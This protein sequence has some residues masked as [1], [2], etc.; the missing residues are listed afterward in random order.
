MS[1]LAPPAAAAD[2]YV[3]TGCAGFIGSHLTDALVARRNTVVGIDGFSDYYSR[4]RKEANLAGLSDHP[5]FRLIEG[6]VCEA[7][8]SRLLDGATGIFH[9]AAQ[10][11][12]RGSWGETFEVYA[13]DNI[14]ATQ[15]VLGAAAATDPRVVL[16]SSSSVYGNA[17]TYPTAEDTRP[18]PISPYGVTKL[19]CEC[20][21]AAYA[22]TLGLDV[23]MLRYFSVYGP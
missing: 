18:L 2:R 11:G 17:E 23:V 7:E 15:R 5:R 10:P 16:A 8:L 9:L 22:E 12:V 13:R 1:D 14:I 3:V 19:A 20:L 6:D 21:A 4:A